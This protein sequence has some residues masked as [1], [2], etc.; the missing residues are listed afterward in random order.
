MNL[1]NSL[2][3]NYVKRS[4]LCRQFAKVLKNTDL[5]LE[6]LILVEWLFLGL[7]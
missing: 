1:E 2:I 6:I 4:C 5:E 7:K 3:S